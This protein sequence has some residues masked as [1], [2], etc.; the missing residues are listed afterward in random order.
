MKKKSKKIKNFNSNQKSFYFEDYLESNQR[1]RKKN[2]SNISEDRIFLLFLFFFS[3]ILVF[4]IKIFL[5]SLQDPRFS[6]NKK[7]NI[8]YVSLRSDIVDRNEEIISRN[9]KA[10]H[11]AIRSNLIKDKKKFLIK[12]KLILP[13]ASVNQINKNLN[14]KKY[15]YLKKRLTEKEKNDL[16]SLGEK[17]IVFEEYQS[18]IYPHAELYSHILGQIDNDNYGISGVEKYFDKDLKNK[19]NINKPLILSLDTNLQ[20][21]V[22]TELK[23]SMNI[24]K[25]KGA[26]GLLMNANNGEVL[27]LVSLPDYNINKRG[28]INNPMYTNKVTKSVY[29][30]GSIFKTFTIALALDR[31]LVE[32][33]TII[34]NIPN[35]IK[36]SVHE[37]GDIKVFP[38]NLSVEDILIRSS[39]IGTLMIARKIG[40]QNYK[41]FLNNINLLDTANFELDEIGSP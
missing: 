16:W 40:K 20:Y 33:E 8:N 25:S 14:E 28:D 37:I 1:Y 22:K 7:S 27:S 10:Y 6:E 18:R 32:P 30:L 35:K 26:A 2:N 41:N 31:G 9:I 5:I 23:K 17:G 34:S 24:F 3:L 38:K 19:D 29:E 36:C 12:I 11:A 15:F 39:N 4:S 21:S 13:N